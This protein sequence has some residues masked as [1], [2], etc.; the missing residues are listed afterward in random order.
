MPYSFPQ[1]AEEPKMEGDGGKCPV[2]VLCRES[3]NANPSGQIDYDRIIYAWKSQGPI[4]KQR[5]LAQHTACGVWQSL[6]KRLNKS[7][8][9]VR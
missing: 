2:D 8:F 4:Y 3:R 1:I 6:T 7:S 5:L 9:K